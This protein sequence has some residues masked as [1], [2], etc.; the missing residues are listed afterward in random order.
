MHERHFT[1]QIVASITQALDSRQVRRPR[2]VK[3]TVGEVYHLV[4]ES[5]RMHYELLTKGTWLEGV[6]LELKEEP[7]VVSC[8]RC[9][10]KGPVEDHHLLM[11]SLCN[12]ADVMTVAGN[13]VTVECEETEKS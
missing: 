5:V 3:V 6:D 1:E 13:K 2:A 7:V 10:A 11:C 8:R 9:G 12:S 4:P